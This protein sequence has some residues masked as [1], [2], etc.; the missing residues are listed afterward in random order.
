MKAHTGQHSRKR[1]LSSY[2]FCTQFAI[3]RVSINM[4]WPVPS[5]FITAA[6]KS[7]FFFISINARR[8]QNSLS[9]TTNLPECQIFYVILKS[10]PTVFP[11][12]LLYFFP[13]SCRGLSCPSTNSTKCQCTGSAP[14]RLFFRTRL[15][16]C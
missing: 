13:P 2:W 16:Q 15:S 6:A 8:T 3:D 1:C 5:F 14:R 11:P 9:K 7:P 4:L 10:R 12:M